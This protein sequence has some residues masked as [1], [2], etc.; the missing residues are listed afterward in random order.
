MTSTR[1]VTARLDLERL[2][3]EL[4]RD[5]L[6]GERRDDWCEGFPPKGE[7]KA[8]TWVA[9]DG[10]APARA[11][12]IAYLVR[13]HTTGLLI[14]GA[15]FHGRPV[16]RAAEVG[17]GLVESFWGRGY[18]TEACAALVS[19]AW[20]SGQIDTLVANNDVENSASKA[21]LKRCGFTPMNEVETYWVM[22]VDS[23]H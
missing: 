20:T 10:N 13:E 3:P 23:A 16:D 21:V 1:L 4:A 17:Y 22:T 2:S 5:I 11:P 18:A 7:Y 6:R 12:F 14:G 15:G 9:S 8:S 19:A